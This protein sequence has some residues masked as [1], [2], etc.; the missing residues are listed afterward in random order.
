MNYSNKEVIYYSDIQANI[1]ERASLNGVPSYYFVNDFMFSKY[2]RDIDLKEI[3]LTGVDENLIYESIIS[4][5]NVTKGTVYSSKEMHW[6]GYIYR[7]IVNFTGYSSSYIFK[8]I[9]LSY[10]RNVYF[11]YH[12]QDVNKAIKVILSDNN[13]TPI[14]SH[15]K[16]RNILATIK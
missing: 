11:S 7:A 5:M 14:N 10:L 1:F 4:N 13:I 2:A 8:N 3:E 9:P 16:I 6:I 12:T 15:L